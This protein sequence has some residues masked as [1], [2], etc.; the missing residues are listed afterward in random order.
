MPNG[1]LQFRK[2]AH[3]WVLPR[4]LA[5]ALAGCC[6]ISNDGGGVA[7]ALRLVSWHR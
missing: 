1:V 3:G 6:T 5:G 7:D 2:R 4:C